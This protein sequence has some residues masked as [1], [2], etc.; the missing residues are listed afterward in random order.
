MAS[1]LSVKMP[2]ENL[3]DKRM[4]KFKNKGKEPTV[5][6]ASVLAIFSTFNSSLLNLLIDSLT[7]S[8]LAE[9]A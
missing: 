7:L 6:C 5:S 2:T 4:S 3:S 9:N 8:L 1:A